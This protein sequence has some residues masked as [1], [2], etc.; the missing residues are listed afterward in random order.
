MGE[1]KRRAVNDPT[2]GQ[3]PKGAWRPK[4]APVPE[5]EGGMADPDGKPKTAKPKLMS[6][7]T[8]QQTV[9]TFGAV[10]TVPTTPWRR[11]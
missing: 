9:D 1:A 8:W 11:A 7:R 2:W 10:V 6:G 3:S 4:P 5:S